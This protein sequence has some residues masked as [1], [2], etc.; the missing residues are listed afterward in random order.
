MPA[1]A[2]GRE[3]GL[4]AR[5]TEDPP[6]KRRLW[7]VSLGKGD[8]LSRRMAGRSSATEAAAQG[9]VV[10]QRVISVSLECVARVFTALSARRRTQPQVASGKA[11]ITNSLGPFRRARGAIPSCDRGLRAMTEGASGLTL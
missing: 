3:P 10:P 8:A 7:Q 5:I 4:G 9:V 2:L 11:R 1:V 6:P